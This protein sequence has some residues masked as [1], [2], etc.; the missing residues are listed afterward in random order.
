MLPG[1]RGLHGHRAQQD[2][3]L[4]LPNLSKVGAELNTVSDLWN[5]SGRY[6]L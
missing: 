4:L 2:F 5:N 1:S 3:T 6:I